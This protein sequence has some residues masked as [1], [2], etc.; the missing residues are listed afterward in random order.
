MAGKELSHGWSLPVRSQGSHQE[1][2]LP[3]ASEGEGLFTEISA[4]GQSGTDSE[5]D[6]RSHPGTAAV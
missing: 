4:Q 5:D 6:M 1:V 2:H 3:S